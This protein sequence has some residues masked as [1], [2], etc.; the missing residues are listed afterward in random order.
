MDLREMRKKEGMGTKPS[1]APR[2]SVPI[3]VE[4]LLCAVHWDPRQLRCEL[5]QSLG[6]PQG[7]LPA[8]RKATSQAGGWDT[9][10]QRQD[11]RMT[12]GRK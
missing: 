12:K 10:L 5:S 11:Q 9:G 2:H 7:R 1:P 4:P 8:T 6:T 3:Q